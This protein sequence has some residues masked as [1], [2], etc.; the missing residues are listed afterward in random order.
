MLAALR[1]KMQVKSLDSISPIELKKRSIRG[2]IIDLDNTMTPWNAMEVG[3][4]VTAWF[5]SLA[6]HNIKCCVVSNN[7]EQ[8]VAGVANAL[9]IPFVY[10]ATK[11]RRRAYYRAME[12]LGTTVQDTAAIGDQLFTD[13]LGGNRLGLFTILVLPISKREWIGTRV[14]RMFERIVFWTMDRLDNPSGSKVH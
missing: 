7:S 12:I 14:M 11:P 13:V 9:G 8:R 2:L 4:K 5:K 10:K 3:P 1:P 6:E